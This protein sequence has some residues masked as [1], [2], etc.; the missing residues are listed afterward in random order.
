MR[1]VPTTSSSRSTPTSRRIPATRLRCSRGST[2]ATPT[3]SSPRATARAPPSRGSRRFARCC[4]SP[5]P[6]LI[7]LVRPIARRARLLVRVPHVPR[8]D[9]R[10][11]LRARW[12][13]LRLRE[14]LRLHGRDRR[15]APRLRGL[16]GGPVRAAL[17][18]EAQGVGDQDRPDDWRL[19]PRDLE[20]RGDPAQAG[21]VDHAGRRV[22]R[23]SGSE[24][25]R[26]GRCRAAFPASG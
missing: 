1:P 12:R 26:S 17:R 20:G 15:E 18:R 8:L 14:G 6:A 16:R 23:R 11:R 24:S 2:R 22:R 7:L 9:R 4:R 3:S 25:S 10:R 19:L 21:A 13:R 5:P